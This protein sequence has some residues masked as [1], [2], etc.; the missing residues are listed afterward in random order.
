MFFDF[1]FVP[2]IST[3]PHAVDVV[4]HPGLIWNLSHGFAMGARLAFHTSSPQYGFTP[5][6]IKSWPIEHSF[7][8]SYFLEF[9]FP[10]RFVRPEGGPSKNAFTFGLHFGVG[11]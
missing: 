8:K 4:V 2:L 10:V 7:F 5:V 11:F 1:E 9:D 6:V 3:T